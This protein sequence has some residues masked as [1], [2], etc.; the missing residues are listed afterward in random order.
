MKQADRLVYAI[1]HWHHNRSFE[2]CFASTK[3]IAEV[4]NVAESTVKNALKRLE[5]KNYI[6]RKSYVLPG[7]KRRR[8]ILP[9]ISTNETTEE[10]D[11]PDIVETE[12]HSTLGADVIKAFHDN[13][14]STDQ[15]LY[16]IPAERKACDRL[17]EE[18]GGLD[19]VVKA[20]K[21]VPQ[22]NENPYSKMSITKPTEL[23]RNWDKLIVAV[24]K[25][26][27]K[28]SSQGKRISL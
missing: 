6:I 20:I 16:R 14:I 22:V 7:G 9:N 17:L 25:M 10:V 5:N 4:L 2:K 27:T 19:N 18:K 12:K 11:V 21:L 3:S 28:Q 26:S 13:K 8:T 15:N 24:R 23:Y 1:I